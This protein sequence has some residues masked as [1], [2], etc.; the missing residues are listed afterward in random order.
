MEYN[1]IMSVHS[2]NNIPDRTV[3]SQSD[4]VL[5]FKN[6]NSDNNFKLLLDVLGELDIK[7]RI[8]DFNPKKRIR[9]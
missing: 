3:L 1:G 6:I 5:I 9:I 7:H 4:C 2:M 8:V